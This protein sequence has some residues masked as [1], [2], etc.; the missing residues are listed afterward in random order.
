MIRDIVQLEEGKSRTIKEI[1][2][3]T[4]KVKQLKNNPILLRQ[5]CILMKQERKLLAQTDYNYV[6][7]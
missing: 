1:K 4:R 5:L 3:L 6:I 2:I 7:K